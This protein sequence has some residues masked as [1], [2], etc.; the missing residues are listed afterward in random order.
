M[1]VNV[2]T[3]VVTADGSCSGNPG[4]GG[5]AAHIEF[6]N[7]SVIRV[8]GSEPNTTTNNRMEM[9]AVIRGLEEAKS[10]EPKTPIRVDS[11]SSYLIHSMDRFD[12][13]RGKN[14]DLWSQLDELNE[15]LNIR[16]H[17]IPRN[18]TEAHNEC[19]ALAK[20]ATARARGVGKRV[21]D[22]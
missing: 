13:D 19:D 3:T 7:G 2:P 9:L 14:L 15:D 1:K 8:T 10:I 11:D 22:R 16:W 20:D 21:N 6:V 4:P 12:W 17:H 18:S 5:W